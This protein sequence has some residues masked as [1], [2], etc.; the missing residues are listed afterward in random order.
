MKIIGLTRIR[1]E[2]N[3]IK[4]TLDHMSEFCD[5]VYIYDDA[6][7]DNTVEI[8]N[9]H[10]IVKGLIRGVIWDE[11]RER[12]E[13]ENRQKVFLYARETANMNEDDWFI[14]LDADER[15]E[16]NFIEFQKNWCDKVDGVKMRLFDFYITEEDKDKSYVER[17]W[18]GPEYR[19]ILFMFKNKNAIGYHIPD[20]REC[21]LTPNSRVM[22][23]GY[24]KHFGKGI[25]IQQWENTC[26]YY[27]THF[28]KYADKWNRRR[29]KAIHTMSDFGRGLIKWED[30]TNTNII[31][32]I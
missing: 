31:I 28:P 10:S 19:D 8:C 32:P 21:F 30:R 6:S 1:N 27:A 14:Y 18:M 17:Q 4:D 12:A 29:G 22:L 26:E 20:Q 15:I 3:I 7:T 2:E 16:F 25:S 13:Y 11:N 9:K 24:V 23:S 5:G